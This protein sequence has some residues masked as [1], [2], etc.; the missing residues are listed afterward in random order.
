[1]L[2]ERRYR[3]VH[4]RNSHIAGPVMVVCYRFYFDM[5]Y[6]PAE[7][8][9]GNLYTNKTIA[10]FVVKH[11]GRPWQHFLEE[12]LSVNFIT[13][14]SSS[15]SSYSTHLKQKKI[16]HTKNTNDKENERN[17]QSV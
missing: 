6:P 10:C 16:I 12:L 14:S 3:D 4:I 1:M 11:L 7:A 15:S 13:T 17:C 2:F 5:F 9:V 8:A